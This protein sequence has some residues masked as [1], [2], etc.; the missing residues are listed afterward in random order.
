MGLAS[1]G[2]LALN[3]LATY[4]ALDRCV[5]KEADCLEVLAVSSYGAVILSDSK[6]I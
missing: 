4:G 1:T 2:E 6:Y 3:N 5:E